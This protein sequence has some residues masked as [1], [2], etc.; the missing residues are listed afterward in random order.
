MVCQTVFQ[1]LLVSKQ[2]ARLADG[3]FVAFLQ[4]W[5]PIYGNGSTDAG[6]KQ[7]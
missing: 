3:R 2:P 7:L 6:A 4:M 1:E 5:F